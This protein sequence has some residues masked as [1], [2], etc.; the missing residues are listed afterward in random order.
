MLAAAAAGGSYNYRHKTNQRGC[1]VVAAGQEILLRVLFYFFENHY[2]YSI[3]LDYDERPHLHVSCPTPEL[4]SVPYPLI[5]LLPLSTC[6][7]HRRNST[8]ILDPVSPHPPPSHLH[9]LPVGT[10]SGGPRSGQPRIRICR[11]PLSRWSI[12]TASVVPTII[13]ISPSC[14]A[15]ALTVSKYEK[16]K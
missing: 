14:S 4:V 13:I 6:P 9:P 8:T 1:R 2:L 5:P 7:H 16:H 11:S 10:S 3:Y 12:A 15:A